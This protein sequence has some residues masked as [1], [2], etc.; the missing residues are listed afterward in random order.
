MDGCQSVVSTP[1]LLRSILLW[2]V[3]GASL[4][5]S[6]LTTRTEANTSTN[7]PI[8]ASSN[9]STNATQDGRRLYKELL[10]KLYKDSNPS[11]QPN[12]GDLSQPVDI[13]I[14]MALESLSDLDMQNQ[15][16]TLAA[17]FE[18]IWY[19]PG[20]A[21][22]RT[23]Y[24][25]D[26]VMVSE[27][28]VWRP[29][30]A[31][32]NSVMPRDQIM[33]IELPLTL[34]A[35]GRLRWF[36]G[37]TV[38]LDC[39][40]DLRFYPFDQQTCVIS[41]TQWSQFEAD[42]NCSE[43]NL[44]HTVRTTGNGEWDIVDLY[45]VRTTWN[46]TDYSFWTVEYFLTIKRKWLFYALNILFPVG[47]VSMLI[48]VVFLLPVDSGDKMSVSVTNF[49]TLAVFMTVVQDSLPQNSDTVCYLAVYLASQLVLGALAVL[50]SAVTVSW[51]HGHEHQQS[52]ENGVKTG[53]E[54]RN[55]DGLLSSHADNGD[56]GNWQKR[57]A[58]RSSSG[59]AASI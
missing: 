29:V 14:M 23:V 50:L 5:G 40:V 42:V 15:M 16:L 3:V 13:S 58:R 39:P 2:L 57:S 28:Q 11:L 9:F 51:C 54:G 20:L 36:P 34:T 27:K 24:P 17:W 10:D 33:K 25:V 26:R 46:M 45:V 12:A 30:L 37:D 43:K 22:D 56:A 38:V 31:L 35:D 44:S 49:L 6:E 52:V 4:V 32:Y 48:S 18:V 7:N 59:I 21:W 55:T 47:L 53:G 19:D 8:T 41:L 1:E